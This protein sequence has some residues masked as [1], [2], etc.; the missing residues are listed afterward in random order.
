MDP[1]LPFNVPGSKHL[2]W[3]CIQSNTLRKKEKSNS[4]FMFF[5]LHAVSTQRKQRKPSVKTLRSPR[6]ANFRGI[7]CWEREL[8]GTLLACYQSE[9]IK[10]LINNNLYTWGH[11]CAGAQSVTAKSSNCGFDPHYLRTVRWMSNDRLEISC[12]CS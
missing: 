10:I 1:D 6:I 7:A 12:R 8:N 4:N 5:Q 9:V 2:F 11:S 3:S